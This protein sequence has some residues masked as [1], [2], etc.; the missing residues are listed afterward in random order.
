MIFNS[1]HLYFLLM[2]PSN[3]RSNLPLGTAQSGAPC[4][5]DGFTSPVMDPAHPSPGAPFFALGEVGAHL[6]WR[7]PGENGEEWW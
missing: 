2:W 1:L 7:P 3:L 4:Y 5:G 6:T